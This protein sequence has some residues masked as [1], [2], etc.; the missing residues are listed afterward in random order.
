MAD[1]KTSKLVSGNVLIIQESEHQQEVTEQ[2]WFGERQNQQYLQSGKE[3][4]SRE[5]NMLYN[6]MQI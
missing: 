4:K 6:C 5:Y 2:A 3:D 1:K